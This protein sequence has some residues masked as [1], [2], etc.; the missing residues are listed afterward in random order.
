VFGQVI[1]GMDVVKKMEVREVVF[2]F[3]QKSQI[4]YTSTSV[5]SWLHSTVSM[6]MEY[7]SK[8]L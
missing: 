2:W 1:S 6:C 4:A 3:V 8:I 7:D 5:A